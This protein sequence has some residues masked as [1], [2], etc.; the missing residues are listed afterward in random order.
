MKLTSSNIFNAIIEIRTNMNGGIINSI[1]YIITDETIVVFIYVFLPTSKID[2]IFVFQVFHLSND[3]KG[4]ILD[5][6]C[7]D[8]F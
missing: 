6:E 2:M 8:K 5:Y 1:F 7:F 4:F 3:L